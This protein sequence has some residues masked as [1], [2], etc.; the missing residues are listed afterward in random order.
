MAP[1]VASA[2]STRQTPRKVFRLS[3][4]PMSRR[5]V[6]RGANAQRSAHLPPSEWVNGAERPPAENLVKNPPDAFAL[7]AIVDTMLI[8]VE[9]LS[10]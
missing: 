9:T 6:G 4:G 10:Q 5:E 1:I 2:A 3:S 7:A 8:E